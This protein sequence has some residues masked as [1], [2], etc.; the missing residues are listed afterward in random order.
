MKAWPACSCLG[1]G[2]SSPRL[3]TWARSAPSSE[4]SSS[5]YRPIRSCGIG[6]PSSSWRGTRPAAV[7]RCWQP[8]RRRLPST[9][10]CPVPSEC[11]I[12][13][14][15]FWGRIGTPLPHPEYARADGTAYESGSVWELEEALDTSRRI[16]P[17][18]GPHLPAHA[19][20]PGRPDRT[21]RRR[22][23]RPVPWTRRP[24]SSGSPIRPPGRSTP[25]YSTYEKPDDFRQRVEVDLRTLVKDALDASDHAPT[26]ADRGSLHSAV[27]GLAV[28][29]T[30]LVHA[31]GRAD[32]LRPWP[33]DRPA[34][35]PSGLEPVRDGHRGERIGQV[36]DRGR[37]AR[38]L[39]WPSRNRTLLLPSFDRDTRRWSGLRFTPGELGPDPFLP[40]AAQ[41]A[42]LVGDVPREIAARL[43]RR[44]SRRST[45]SD[46]TS[47]TTGALVFCDQFEE[48][49]TVVARGAPRSVHR[50]A[51]RDRRRRPPP[52]R[53]HAA[54]GLLPAMC[55]AAGPRPADGG[56]PDPRRGARPTSCSR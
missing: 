48:L 14:A 37:R 23:D 40:L 1:S 26:R 7:R 17:P 45:S 19:S 38:S 51:R 39:G 56:R 52:S 32:L 8:E 13:I 16:G 41:L 55:G 2:C 21:R 36:I 5:N 18:A 49:F 50:A 20:E 33:R 11:D 22:A 35:Q 9:P 53:G 46:A 10:G 42:P 28:P 54:L 25:R 27:A 29:R 34:R 6:R 47:G 44:R 3:A 15:V 12:V 30:A 24:T 31:G 4:P 43:A